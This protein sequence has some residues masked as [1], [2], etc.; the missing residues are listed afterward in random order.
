MIGD[1]A[2]RQLVFD[3]LLPDPLIDAALR[4]R[5]RDTVIA[6][7]QQGRAIWSTSPAAARART[8]VSAALTTGKLQPPPP[9]RRYA[10]ALARLQAS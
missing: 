6:F 5:Y 3:P 2:I 7:D 8:T 1:H 10:P 4:R 9:R